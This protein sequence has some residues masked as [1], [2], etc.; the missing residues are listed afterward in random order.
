MAGDPL[1]ELTEAL[2]EATARK[3]GDDLTE[4]WSAVKYF[5]TDMWAE[6]TDAARN[7]FDWIME[8]LQPIIDKVNE[9]RQHL[10]GAHIDVAPAPVAVS[11]SPVAPEIAP[12]SLIPRPL[13]PRMSATLPPVALPRQ[14]VPHMV[15]TLP[16]A[17]MPVRAR[18]REARPTLGPERVLKT[19][20]R[21]DRHEVPGPTVVDHQVGGELRISIDSDGRPKVRKLR[22]HGGIR[23]SVNTGLALGGHD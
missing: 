15:A 18:M 17:T 3:V 19:P 9:L 12:E 10:P 7:S 14:L 1:H 11:D 20:V 16:R 22:S 5:F 13:V 8:K 4:R 6:I 23:L 2:S 21:A